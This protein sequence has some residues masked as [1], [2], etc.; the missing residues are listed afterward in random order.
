MH[1]IVFMDADGY[2]RLLLDGENILEGSGLNAESIVKT[3][4]AELDIGYEYEEVP[5]NFF[6]D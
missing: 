1:K 2:F 5:D 6:W 4:C 3:L